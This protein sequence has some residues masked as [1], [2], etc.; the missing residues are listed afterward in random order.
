MKDFVYSPLQSLLPHWHFF[1]EESV[2]SFFPSLNQ[3]LLFQEMVFWVWDTRATSFLHS[4]QAN[5]L[6]PPATSSSWKIWTSILS[7]SE[8]LL[9]LSGLHP[10]HCKV[11]RCNKSRFLKYMCVP[12]V[13][14]WFGAEE[15]IRSSLP[16]AQIILWFPISFRVKIKFLN[17]DGL[18][19]SIDDEGNYHIVA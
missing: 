5:P 10:C 15:R 17:M 16:S 19:F 3:L 12:S 2:W 7:L 14:G 11:C 13:A 8:T 18:T 4:N 1:S 9:L 6:L